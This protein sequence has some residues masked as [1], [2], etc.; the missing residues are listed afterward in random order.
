MKYLR[1]GWL[2]C[3]LLVPT[4]VGQQPGQGAGSGSVLQQQIEQLEQELGDGPKSVDVH[5]GPGNNGLCAVFVTVVNRATGASSG[6]SNGYAYDCK[7]LQL[8]FRNSPLYVKVTVKPKD[9]D[10]TPFPFSLSPLDPILNQLPK[11]MRGPLPPSSPAPLRPAATSDPYPV[12]LDLPL[13]PPLSAGSNT[14]PSTGCD[15]ARQ[16]TIFRVNHEADNVMRFD[17][18]PLQL[19]ATIPVASAPLQAELTPDNKTL[20]V[21]SYNNAVTF[22]DTTTNKVAY[23]LMT[24]PDVYPAG[25]AITDDGRLAYVVSFIDSNPAVIIIDV[26]NRSILAR[27]PLP[28]TYPNG[29]FLAP[30]GATA[31]ITHPLT[32]QLDLFDVLT[33]SVV[34]SLSIGTPHAVAFDRTGTRAFVSSGKGIT[35]FSTA[36]LQVVDSYNLGGEP[37]NLLL[38]PEGRYLLV[39][40]Y[41][42]TKNWLIDLSSR[43]VV[44]VDTGLLSPGSVVLQ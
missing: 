25:I 22:V 15:P 43:N 39:E 11:A 4:L 12:V 41:S 10:Q 8:E 44:T 3:L 21:T 40:D 37:S 29:I 30:D 32:N 9:Q 36:T 20:V 19:T 14:N 16:Y 33:S 26:V 5:L 18:C 1:L 28:G 42:S 13:A 7:D 2:S 24:P 34:T 31:F 6:F 23:T 17:G 35:I 27:I 38:S